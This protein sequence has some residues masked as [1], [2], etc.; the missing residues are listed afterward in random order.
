MKNKTLLLVTFV[1]LLGFQSCSSKK[2]FVKQTIET[3]KIPILL[4]STYHFVNQGM[5]TYNY[6]IDNYFT[7]KRQSEIQ[8]LISALS[9]FKPTKVLIEQ[10]PNLQSK[11]DSLYSMYKN[12]NL[13]FEKLEGGQNEMYQIGYK[14]SKK[15]NLEKVHCIDADGWFLGSVVQIVADS[16]NLE[17][18]LTY[19][20]SYAADSKND[21]DYIANHTLLENF[22]KINSQDEI[23]EKHYDYNNHMIKVKD[24]QNIL[25]SPYREKPMEIDGYKYMM[26]SLDGEN[27][28]VE[29][30]I[31]WF[32]RNVRIYANILE[33]AEGQDRIILIIG[34]SHIRPLQLFFQ[35]NPDFHL[36]ETLDYL[37]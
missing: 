25:E 3:N 31:E 22:R 19:K 8:D 30:Y 28:G 9:K 10:N 23:L 27:I 12:D 21:N 17:N 35:D 29:T 2:A 18:Y 34:T 14:L 4:L 11:H 13:D 6:D 32:K 15:N 33:L 26:R 1:I 24:P 36:V 20:K 7:E 5:D 16:M 37:N